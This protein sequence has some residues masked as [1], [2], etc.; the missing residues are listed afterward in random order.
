MFKAGILAAVILVALPAIAQDYDGDPAKITIGA[1]LLLAYWKD[2]DF[3]AKERAFYYV[4][5][6]EIPTPRWTTYD[7]KFFKVKLPEGCPTAIQDR[8]YTSPIWHTP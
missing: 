7:A 6:I 4:R 3:D 2:P 8:A 1:P 5:V